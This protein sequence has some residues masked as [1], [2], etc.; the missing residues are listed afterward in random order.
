MSMHAG[1]IL[2]NLGR[3][4]DATF[5]DKWKEDERLKRILKSQPQGASTTVWA[6]AASELEG[7]GGLYLEE[8][9]IADKVPQKDNLTAADPGYAPYAYEEAGE[10]R[11]WEESCKMVG[12][13]A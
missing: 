10:K 5:F 11:L 3:H 7:R 13:S 6:A 8:C 12:L 2:T 1:C 9:R 4:L